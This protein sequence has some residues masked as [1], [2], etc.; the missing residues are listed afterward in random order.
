[1]PTDGI[2]HDLEALLATWVRPTIKRLRRPTV[3]DPE[4]AMWYAAYLQERLNG[5]LATSLGVEEIA[6]LLTAAEA[7][8]AKHYPDA[9]WPHFYAEYLLERYA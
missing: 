4:W 9:E 2:E 3:R 5:L 7:E 1:M 6:G 8:R